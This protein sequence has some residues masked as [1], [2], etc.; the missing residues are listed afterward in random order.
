MIRGLR[1]KAYVLGISLS[2]L[3]LMGGCHSAGTATTTTP[4]TVAIA[5]G[6]APASLTVGQTYQFSATVTNSTNTGVTWAVG[7]VTGGNSTL[8]TISRTGLYTAPRTVPTPATFPITVTSN[9]D[10]SKSAS[11]NV[12]VTTTGGPVVVTLNGSASST[13]TATRGGTLPVTALV[14]GATVALTFTVNGVTGGNSS[15][16]T[17]AGSYPSYTYNAPAAI[18]GNNNPVTIVATQGGTGQTASVTVTINP[19][20][21]TP[22]A[23]S[24]TGGNVTGVNLSLTSMTTTLGLADVGTCIGGGCGASVTGIQVSRSGVAT[25][26]CP[27]STTPTICNVWLVGQGLTDTLGDPTT[28]MSV[29]VTGGSTPDVTVDGSTLTGLTPS[30]GFS[31]VTFNIQA[32]TTATLG[33]RDIVVTVGSAPTQQTQVYLGAIQIVN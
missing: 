33:L 22:N 25:S 32:S 12:T 30:G 8:G 20:T 21:T 15:L 17:V 29:S 24:V 18:P 5:L 26:S 13:T 27:A 1:R 4:A 31:S 7:G 6:T 23:I 28:G 10:V 11:L 2:L 16:G 14:T 3:A 9:S 19:S